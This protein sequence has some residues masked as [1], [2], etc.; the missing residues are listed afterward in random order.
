MIGIDEV[1][2]GCW[3][4]PL[5]V[6]A[7]RPIGQLP[8]RLGDSKSFSR[9]QREVIYNKLQKSCIFGEGWVSSS[10]IDTSGL[11]RAL[12]VGAQRALRALMAALNEEIIIDG[13]INYAPSKY[14]Q[15]KC[16]IKADSSVPLVSAAA[17]YAKVTR[18]KYM[19]KLA[20]EHPAYGFERH[21]GYGTK[22]HQQAILKKGIIKNVHR[23]SFK[24]IRMLAEVKL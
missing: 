19:T 14:T 5:L 22:A 2:R 9:L 12:R 17:V 1:G 24:P 21:V 10:E 23:L 15:T 3:A 16:I 4:G 11:P 8:H 13:S 6:V 18:D 20:A 7:S